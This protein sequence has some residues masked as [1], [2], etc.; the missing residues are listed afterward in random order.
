MSGDVSNSGVSTMR[1]LISSRFM[2]FSTECCVCGKQMDLSYPPQTASNTG[3]YWVMC[4]KKCVELYE[5][6]PVLYEDKKH[7]INDY[8]SVRC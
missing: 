8:P 3:N 4:S 6:F 1:S 7:N 5:L 2:R